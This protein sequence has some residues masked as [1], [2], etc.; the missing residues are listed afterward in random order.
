MIFV[1][2]VVVIF[3]SLIL[4]VGLFISFI[5]YFHTWLTDVSVARTHSHAYFEALYARC[6]FVLKENK[7]CVIS[8]CV[9]QRSDSETIKW[10]SES[11]MKRH[12]HAL[13]YVRKSLKTSSWY[14]SEMCLC[15]YAPVTKQHTIC[16]NPSIFRSIAQEN[17]WIIPVFPPHKILNQKKSN[18]SPNLSFSLQFSFVY[19]VKILFFLFFI[20]VDHSMQKFK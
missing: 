9:N 12:T 3:H 16:T 15:V 14:K 10:K 18:Q 2:V 1:V 4:R 8:K 6:T 20:L 13:S 7:R 17:A 11:L 19:V 5:L